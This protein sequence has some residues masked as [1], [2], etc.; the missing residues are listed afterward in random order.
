MIKNIFDNDHIFYVS[1]KSNKRI[2]DNKAK[3]GI[4]SRKSLNDKLM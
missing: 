1:G 3:K 2:G 4:T